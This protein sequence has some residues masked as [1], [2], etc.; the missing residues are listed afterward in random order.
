[1]GGAVS[2]LRLT[3]NVTC[4]VTCRASIVTKSVVYCYCKLCTA[5]NIWYTNRHSAD[6]WLT[7]NESYKTRKVAVNAGLPL[8]ATR[9]A[10]SN[11]F[12]YLTCHW[13][14]FQYIPMP[15]L[16]LITW[17]GITHGSFLLPVQ[18]DTAY[19]CSTYST[20]TLW[21]LVTWWLTRLESWP[22]TAA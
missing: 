4:N 2:R 13:A 3:T 7:K 1:V 19:S 22:G 12:A 17:H 16:A 6:C 20:C 5:L 11:L 9:S 8:K 21:K 14:Y 18:V 15:S 10:C